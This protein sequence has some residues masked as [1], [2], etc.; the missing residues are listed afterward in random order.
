MARSMAPIEG[1]SNA[2]TAQPLVRT[3][4]Q[5]W[6]EADLGA[7]ATAK[8]KVAFDADKGDKQGPITVGAAVS[9]PATVT[10]PASGN[11]TPGSPDSARTPETRIVA[12]G[13]S[14]FVTNETLGFAGNRDFFM[15]TLNWLSQQENLIAIRPR[16]P[17]DHRLTLTED[18]TLRIL[19]LSLVVIPGLVFVSGIYTWWKRR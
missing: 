15:N 9:A 17:Q 19:I 8:S 12:L 2:H 1:G 5:S 16:Q 7:L 11:S 10:P 18:Q 14:D 13:D 3:S 6:S 4:D